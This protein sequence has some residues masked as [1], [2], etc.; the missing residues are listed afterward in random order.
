M[1]LQAQN[2]LDEASTSLEVARENE[3]ALWGQSLAVQEVSV[4]TRIDM[5]K[6]DLIALDLNAARGRAWATPLIAVEWNKLDP[7]KAAELLQAEQA[8]VENQTGLYRDLQLR[9]L[10]LAWAQVDVV[11]LPHCCTDR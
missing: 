10:S 5:E 6:A 1:R 8:A 9:G 11:R 2:L 7:V 4:G 3:E